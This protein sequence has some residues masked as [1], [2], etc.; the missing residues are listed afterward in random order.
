MVMTALMASLSIG[1]YINYIL[2]ITAISS[3]LQ[4]SYQESQ[5]ASI[6]T[7]T[8]SL[9]SYLLFIG[10]QMFDLSIYS[11]LPCLFLTYDSLLRKRPQLLWP[12]LICLSFHV[13]WESAMWSVCHAISCL[14]VAFSSKIYRVK[15]VLFSLM[16]AIVL[17]FGYSNQ[18]SYIIGYK[19]IQ[20]L[21][22]SIQWSEYR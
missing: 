13:T 5:P 17:L 18:N 20:P 8:R 12:P 16:I 3:I 15:T 10:M 11:I 14:H 1:S 6:Y 19:W 2:S 21:D 22:N 7:T 9:L 4:K